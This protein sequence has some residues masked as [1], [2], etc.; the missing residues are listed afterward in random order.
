VRVRL[1]AVAAAALVAASAAPAA[2]PPVAARAYVV[3]NAATGEVLAARAPARRLPMASITKL[4]TVLVTLEHEPLSHVVTVARGAASVGESSIHLAAG[5]RL[6]VRDLVEAALI[7]SANDA[8][9]ALAYDVG[10]G[11]VGT[12]VALMNTRARRLGLRDTHFTRPDGLD[13]AGHYSSARDLTLLARVVMHEPAVRRIVRQRTAT[14]AG[15]RILHTWNDLLGSFPGLIG[16]K[17]G[18]TAAAGWCE[19]GAVRARGFSIY[20]T[21]LGSPT[22]AQRNADLAALL[23]WGLSRYRTVAVVERGRVYTRVEVGYGRTLALVAQRPLVR[24]VRVD[25]PLTQRVVAD[26]AVRLPVRKG[27]VLGEVRAFEGRKLLGVRPLVAARSVAP[28]GVIGRIRWYAGRT[29]HHFVGF[30][31]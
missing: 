1:T 2:P 12:F 16:V 18:H 15:G 31:S 26:A 23:R 9:D 22:R 13:A 25:R 11:D 24:A 10:H 8:A 20:V 4:M 27:Q 28:P 19:V 30:F 6:T 21:V 5:E 7:Q 3:E 14:I 17:T 29:V